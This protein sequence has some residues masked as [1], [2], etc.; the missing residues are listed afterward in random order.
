MKI[1]ML[2][3]AVGTVYGG[4]S[5]SVVELAQALGH[6]SIEVDLI[7]TNANGSEKLNVPLQTWISETSYRFQYF[8]YWDLKG[9]KFSL[10]LTNW[11]FKNASNYDLVHANAVFSY[12]NLPAYWACQ[13]QKIPYL[14]TPRGMLEPWALSYKAWKKRLYYNLFEKP[15][16]QQ[17]SAIQTLAKKEA[18][19]V[20]ILDLKAPIF[21]VPNGVH[22]QDFE[23]LPEPENFYSKFPETRNKTLILFLGRIDPKKGLDLLSTAFAKIHTL[24]PHTHL[25]VAGQDNIGYLPVVKDYFAQAGCIDAV[26]FTGMLTGSLKHSALA[27]ANIYVA[28]SYSEGFSMSVLEGMAS[29]LPCVITTGCNFSE[30]ASAQAAYVVNVNA[31]ELADALTKCLQN[32][33][34]AKQMGNRARQLVFENYTWERVAS[35]LIEIYMSIRKRE[36]ISAVY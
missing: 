29:G 22:K 12:A 13:Q 14:V 2:V 27:A 9:Y 33:Q 30:A 28:P 16:L 7:T 34:Q 21:V 19:G 36:P 31:E 23:T 25:I 5:K 6:H 8:P 1:L 11:L 18:E 35:Q 15:A 17:A 24:F 26:T 3:P 20:K 32:P 4:P 10:A